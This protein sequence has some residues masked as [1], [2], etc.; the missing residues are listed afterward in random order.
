MLQRLDL[1]CPGDE[2]EAGASLGS[3]RNIGSMDGEAADPVIG[4]FL[5]APDAD[6]ARRAGCSAWNRRGA[7]ATRGTAIRS[8]GRAS[9]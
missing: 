1:V 4:A 2:L 3:Y 7:R 9:S 8:A 6:A 5:R